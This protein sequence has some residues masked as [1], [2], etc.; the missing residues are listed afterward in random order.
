MADDG[1]RAL[2]VNTPEEVLGDLRKRIGA[3]R[4]VHR[5]VQLSTE[6]STT[7][8]VRSKRVD[9]LAATALQRF[10]PQRRP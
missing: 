3:T 1:I 8:R 2:S 10:A 5:L 9:Q 4:T 6:R 7:R